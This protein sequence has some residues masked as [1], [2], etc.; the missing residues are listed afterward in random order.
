MEFIGVVGADKG[1]VGDGVGKG[2][3][4]DA[5]LIQMEM[6]IWL[7]DDM[8]VEPSNHVTMQPLAMLERIEDGQERSDDQGQGGDGDNDAEELSLFFG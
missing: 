2:K 6:A 5:I 1:D 7:D 3:H 8:V 4:I